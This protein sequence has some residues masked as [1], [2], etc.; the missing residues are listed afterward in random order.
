MGKPS[1]LAVDC[2]SE[3]MLALRAM[4]GGRI[5]AGARHEDQEFQ[6]IAVVEV[7]LSA[8]IPALSPV[9]GDGVHYGGARLIVRLHTKTIGVVNIDFGDGALSSPEC[10]RAIW[11]NLG[12]KINAH[13]RADLLPEVV[14]IDHDGLGQAQSPPCVQRREAVLHNP[15]PVS[16]IICSRNRA[17]RLT[18]TL[19][20]FAAMEHP[21]YE[22][23]VIDGFQS[24]ETRGVVHRQ[25]PNVRYFPVCDRGRS[26]ALNRGI[27]AEVSRFR[28]S[29]A[30]RR[31]FGS[32]NPDDSPMVW[33]RGRSA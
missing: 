13:L 23:L 6:P 12:S 4:W 26:F 15:T 22:L 16:V 7:E 32:R 24:E 10:A 27:G 14:G 33:S 21:D 8:A 29:C 19:A 1:H 5:L 28:S 31:R 17:D 3:A 9:G 18:R 11:S 30:P 2:S 25:F 20:S